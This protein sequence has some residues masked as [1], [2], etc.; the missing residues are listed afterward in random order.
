[1]LNATTHVPG[2]VTSSPPDG[3]VD[4]MGDR[5]FRASYMAHHLRAF[6]A[7]QI[8]NLRGARSQKQFGAAIGKPQSVVSRLEN[9][10]YGRVTLQSLIDIAEK[11]DIAL[12]VRYVDFPTFIAATRDFSE[13]AVAPPRYSDEAMTALLVASPQMDA[14]ADALAASTREPLQAGSRDIPTGAPP[15]AAAHPPER[16]VPP[17]LPSLVRSGMSPLDLSHE[18]GQESDRISQRADL[19]NLAGAAWMEDASW[20]R[21]AA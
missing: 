3:L 21:Q 13:A 12:L 1:M 5:P 16:P 2:M 11:L 8:R 4:A 10:D 19:G 15:C 17:S 20:T 7:D 6:L 14:P 9:E 18:P